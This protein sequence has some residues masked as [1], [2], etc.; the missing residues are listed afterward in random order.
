[1]AGKEAQMGNLPAGISW[2]RRARGKAGGE[3]KG[4]TKL[5]AGLVLIW[6]ALGLAMLGMLLVER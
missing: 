2:K 4:K 6:M 1:M 5:M 3:N